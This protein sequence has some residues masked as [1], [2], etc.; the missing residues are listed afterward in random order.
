MRNRALVVTITSVLVAILINVAKINAQNPVPE[1]PPNSTTIWVYREFYGDPPG[2]ILAIPFETG[3]YPDDDPNDNEGA[4]N[5][6]IAGVLE[7]E[8]GGTVETA[9]EDWHSSSGYCRSCTN[10]SL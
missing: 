8:I 2:E 4:L 7:A 10:S 1:C 3:T 5:N 9:L 6:Y